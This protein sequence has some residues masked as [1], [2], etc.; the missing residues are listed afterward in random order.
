MST[1]IV[2]ASAARRLWPV[3]HAFSA[4]LVDDPLH[5]AAQLLMRSAVEL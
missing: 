5:L 1:V 3:N 4:V 2:V